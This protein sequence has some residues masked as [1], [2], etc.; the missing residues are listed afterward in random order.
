[1]HLLREAEAETPSLHPGRGDVLDEAS[2][3]EQDADARSA[4]LRVPDDVAVISRRV[5]SAR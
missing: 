1:L 3:N 4:G 2:L 5:D